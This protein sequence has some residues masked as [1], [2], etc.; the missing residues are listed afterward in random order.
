MML[1]NK[2]Q[3]T[4]E[5]GAYEEASELLDRAI[6]ANLRDKLKYR[7]ETELINN[8]NELGQIRLLQAKIHKATGNFDEAVEIIY[9][10]QAKLTD[11]TSRTD[12]SILELKGESF[13]LLAEMGKENH[14]HEEVSIHLQD[15]S[16][17]YFNANKVTRS[18]NLLFE[19]STYIDENS[20]ETE[21]LLIHNRIAKMLG[22]IRDKTRRNYYQARFYLAK[23]KEFLYSDRN[24]ALNLLNKADKAISKTD[25]KVIGTRIKF[26]KAQIL[27]YSSINDANKII[28]QLE[29][30]KTHFS[31][32]VYSGLMDLNKSLVQRF[33]QSIESESLQ[34]QEISGFEKCGKNIS[35]F[36]L[37]KY[38]FDLADA[39]LATSYK[40][41]ELNLALDYSSKATELFEKLKNKSAKSIAFF[42][43]GLIKKALGF[44]EEGDNTIK[45]SKIN[46]KIMRTKGEHIGLGHHLDIVIEIMTS[47]EEIKSF[48]DKIETN[49]ETL[50]NSE[51]IQILYLLS[52]AIPEHDTANKARAYEETIY[53]ADKY[54]KKRKDHVKLFQVIQNKIV[55]TSGKPLDHEI[56][57]DKE[58]KTTITQ[59]TG[60]AGEE[61]SV[62]QSKVSLPQPG[63]T[64]SIKKH[65]K[66]SGMP[67]L[68]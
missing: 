61:K 2:A 10:M 43:R 17:A 64:K 15:A 48:G 30:L 6:K 41:E 23:S 16:T 50:S 52:L 56:T 46:F 49:Y 60:I 26:R 9:E 21:K 63:S 24:E 18:L 33:D 5:K 47:D 42:Q 38:Y 3:E 57:K 55:N 67:E 36:E 19:L 39:I 7:Q 62:K 20:L 29:K 66:S 25:Q 8:R 28:K 59:D 12:Q 40:S 58:I 51:K 35:E 11:T 44:A 32:E 65:K 37:A 53:L 68:D 27:K 45:L 31:G 4:Y 1:F 22:N 14:K 54:L 34:T 13:M